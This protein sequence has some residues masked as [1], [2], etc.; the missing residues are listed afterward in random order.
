MRNV[1]ILKEAVQLYR[2]Y[3]FQRSEEIIAKYHERFAEIALEALAS[4]GRPVGVML[5]YWTNDGVEGSEVS[6]AL[7]QYFRSG[8]DKGMRHEIKTQRV[9]EWKEERP[10]GKGGWHHHEMIFMDFSKVRMGSL[11]YIL[12]ELQGKRGMM[13]QYWLSRA[14]EDGNPSRIHWHRVQEHYILL[15]NDWLGYLK[16]AE[17]PSKQRTKVKAQGKRN[18][19]GSQVRRWK[20][21]DA[22]FPAEE[23]AA[24]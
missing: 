16:H 8:V 22:M 23:Q 4:M 21:W 18:T 1:K 5:T 20:E 14:D 15:E 2:E 6:E 10:D 17:Y 9:M 24:A 3:K 11:I 12:N 13:K 19:G 7:K